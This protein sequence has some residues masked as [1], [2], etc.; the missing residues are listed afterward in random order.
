MD[1]LR[2]PVDPWRLTESFYD[3][4]D[5]GTTETLFA[6]GNGYLGMRGKVE[7]GH[8][9]HS[10]GTFINGFHE[11]WPIHHAEEAYGLAR[12]GQTIVNVPD[13]KIMRLFVDDEPLRLSV[14]DIIAY[15]RTLDF[16][17]G[18]L[19]RD[20]L[21]RT[22]A[23]NR[24]HVRSRRMVSF[25]HRHLAVLSLEVTVL[26][27]AVPIAITS[28]I[29]NRQDGANEYRARFADKAAAGPGKAESSTGR[30]L[31]PVEHHGDDNRTLLG[32]RCA[33]S[34]MTLAIGTDHQ[35]E[36]ENEYELLTEVGQDH[37][38]HMFRI[39]ALPGKKVTITKTVSYHTS[40]NVPARELVHR[41]RRTL[42][43]VRAQGVAQHF[44]DQRAWLDS[45]WARS[46]VEIEGQPETQQA[47]RWNLF[48]LAQ[49]AGR[50]DGAGIATKGVTGSG[51]GGHCFGHT[52]LYVGPYLAYTTPLFARNALRFRYTLLPAAE[53]RARELTQNGAMFPWR[54]INGEE[55]SA[56]YA[57]GTAQYHINADISYSLSQYVQASGDEEFMAREGIDILVQT[58]RMWADL[59]FW[60]SNGREDTFRIHGV[61]GPDEYTT[62][63]NDNLF[64]NVMARFN[65]RRAAQAVQDLE[66]TWPYQHARMIAR[67]GLGAEEVA[68]CTSTAVC[69]ATWPTCGTTPPRACTSPLP[70]Q[71]GA[72]LCTGSPG[73]VTTAGPSPSTRA[74]LSRGRP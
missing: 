34:G 70:G 72:P 65:L 21:W 71:F 42:D 24:V 47:I 53:R 67:L 49:A 30:V 10:H 64:T 16:A 66:T 45:Y 46:D 69:S 44:T 58:A 60:R 73:C 35:I 37:A 19:T 25:T 38:R 36:T 8:D 59:G 62:V 40:R 22:P 55:A 43:R 51:Y 48:Q 6:V 57:V 3:A 18:V 61:T 32:Y 15:E 2:F 41:C 1:R 11:T 4:G 23:G 26:D 74:C 20:L 12:V 33:N 54:T 68:E 5:L 7:E 56:D 14:A 27:R 31:Q 52:G 17:E 13:A 63:V 29:L 39:D 28:H 50:A 9:S